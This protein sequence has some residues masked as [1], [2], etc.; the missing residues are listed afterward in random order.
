MK[1]GGIDVGTTGCKLTVYN[2]NGVFLHKSYIE[3]EIN[4]NT[5]KHEIDGTIIWNGVKSVIKETVEKLGNID[6]IGIT[7]FGETFLLLDRD[8]KILLPSMLYTDPRGTEE[9]ASFD[10]SQ[11]IKIAGVKPHAMYSLPKIMWIKNN[12]PEIYKRAEKILLF[13]DY[14]VYMLT[15]RAQI[16]YSLAAR[17]MGFDIK[18]CRWSKELFQFAGIDIKKMSETVPSG[19][20]A[21]RIKP[22]L[23]ESL[24]LCGT[25]V[26][27]GCH[28]QVASAAGSGV[29]DTGMAV[30]GTG[31]VECI[32]PVF[33][34]IPLNE[35]LY[36]GGYSIVPY[37]EKGKY[38][39][40]ALSYTGGAAIKWFRDNFSTGM[41]YEEL[42]ALIDNT[43]G[44]ILVLPHFAGAANPYMDSFSKAAFVGVT[45]ETTKADIYKA[46]MEGVTY[47]MLLNL[48]YLKKAG[49][50]PQVLYAA[51]GGA[52][53]EVWMQMKANILGI[54]ITA[55]D[56]PEVGSVGTIMLTGV[57]VGAFKDMRS[58][59]GI[60]VKKRKIYHP[61][62]ILHKK[63]L[64]VY[65]RYEK[66]YAAVRSLMQ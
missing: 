36:D 31:T 23:E 40:Y 9:A 59:A 13:E 17:T 64:K 16:D 32:T 8:D 5:G 55:L 18:E 12:K 42:D 46:I 10:E 24:G 2:E 28:D 43:P 62:T 49:I 60:M 26:I 61:E 20:V 25:I 57:A 53:S 45:L 19:T 50:K 58:A 52:S 11:V 66:L 27:N 34:K 56:A 29:F 51:G 6:A 33:D 41:S 38:V 47:E 4:R 39:C 7:T 44:D 22:E 48:N 21:G 30:D 65:E 1:L 54:S 37:I 3:Y 63:H 35:A 15:G 14:I